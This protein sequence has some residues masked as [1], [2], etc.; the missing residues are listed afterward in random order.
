MLI[1]AD[2]QHLRAFHSQNLT[3]QKIFVGGYDELAQAGS[4]ELNKVPCVLYA[5][6]ICREGQNCRFSHD[7][8]IVYKMDF[9]E[10]VNYFL[11]QP[12]YPSRKMSSEHAF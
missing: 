7:E 1:L 11:S 6:G 5:N 10:P 2:H 4:L 12:R 9:L 8:S 3:A